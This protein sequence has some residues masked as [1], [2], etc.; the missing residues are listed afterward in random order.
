MHDLA[1]EI[2]RVAH[3]SAE[4]AHP[5]HHSVAAAERHVTAAPA[6]SI[7]PRQAI[8]LPARDTTADLTTSATTSNVKPSDDPNLLQVLGYMQAHI[9]SLSEKQ[10]LYES[11]FVSKFSALEYRIEAL[12]AALR[13]N[14]ESLLSIQRLLAAQSAST[15]VMASAAAAGE[16]SEQRSEAVTSH[17]PVTPAAAANTSMEE[18]TSPEQPRSTL[19][20]A[21]AEQQTTAYGASSTLSSSPFAVALAAVTASAVARSPHRRTPGTP[22]NQSG[23][24]NEL[25]MSDLMARLEVVENRV[26]QDRATALQ[27]ALHKQQQ[28]ERL[29][30]RHDLLDILVERSTASPG[31]AAQLSPYAGLLA[32]SQVAGASPPA[33]AVLIQSPPYHAAYLASPSGS[34]P[35]PL[36]HG[37]LSPQQLQQLPPQYVVYPG[38]APYMPPP[39]SS[40]AHA[41][42]T[43]QYVHSPPPYQPYSTADVS[44]SLPPPAPYA[45]HTPVKTYVPVPSPYVPDDPAT[46]PHG[47]SQS[48]ARDTGGDVPDYSGRRRFS[49]AADNLPTTD[50]PATVEMQEPHGDYNMNWQSDQQ[51]A[52]SALRNRAVDQALRTSL[53]TNREPPSAPAAEKESSVRSEA[54][55]TRSWVQ[56]APVGSYRQQQ[57]STW[58]A[59]AVRGSPATLA[60]NDSALFAQSLPAALS[61]ASD[62]VQ[63]DKYTAFRIGSVGATQQSAR[64]DAG[65]T[66][67]VKAG[68]LT[69]ADGRTKSAAFEGSRGASGVNRYAYDGY[70]RHETSTATPKVSAPPVAAAA[71]VP[72]ALPRNEETSSLSTRGS[73]EG[74]TNTRRVAFRVYDRRQPYETS[75]PSY[76]YQRN[77]AAGVGARYAGADSSDTDSSLNY[78]VI[79]NISRNSVSMAEDTLNS[80]K[81]SIALADRYRDSRSSSEHHR[82]LLPPSPAAAERTAR[83]AGRNGIAQNGAGSESFGGRSSSEPPQTAQFS[84]APMRSKSPSA[85]HSARGRTPGFMMP[86]ASNSSKTTNAKTSYAQGHLGST[87]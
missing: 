45:D 82:L 80:T 27:A 23:E 65:L 8:T 29:Q 78:S 19:L 64:D 22:A 40:A 37:Y 1:S 52:L 24:G 51:Y 56:E 63:G 41:A 30:Q 42:Y 59:D 60:S 75:N 54:P 76:D 32:A 35:S 2:D 74:D 46:H 12:E 20:T 15:A 26:L 43:P 6:A 14:N 81:D 83:F 16:T 18:Q 11:A 21:R 49:V 34:V 70:E 3:L 31:T 61:A 55:S 39:P 4:K 85:T 53:A 33:A 72:A 79:N 77:G 58:T 86:T 5:A 13:L 17:K 25:L 68:A 69:Q 9:T 84:A 87:H 73:V 66:F 71:S 50:A 44:T 28:Q 36:L 47:Q 48:Q 38:A 67:S 57:S 62:R 7:A 10:Q